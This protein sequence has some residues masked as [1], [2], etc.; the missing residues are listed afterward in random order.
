M[1][2]FFSYSEEFTHR[3]KH[4]AAAT[5]LILRCSAA[6][7][8]VDLSGPASASKWFNTSRRSSRVSS[9]GGL[10]TRRERWRPR[11]RK[12]RSLTKPC[13]STSSIL[14]TFPRRWRPRLN[15]RQRRPP[16]LLERRGPRSLTLA[17]R[18]ESSSEPLGKG[19]WTADCKVENIASRLTNWHGRSEELIERKT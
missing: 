13:R 18:A 19:V 1:R 11:R 15:V 2:K 10:S 5:L 14:V 3:H 8:E 17:M 7:C 9:S 4:D 16:L 6:I 12:R